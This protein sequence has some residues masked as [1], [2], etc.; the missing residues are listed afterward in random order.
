MSEWTPPPGH[1]VD[2]RAEREAIEAVLER[3]DHLDE[4]ALDELPFGLIQLDET[5]RILSFNRTEAELAQINR[6]RQIGRNFFDE[7]A[8]C[9]RVKAFHGRFLSGVARKELNESFGFLFQ[10]PHGARYVAIT[11]YYSQRKAS[12]WV[13]VSKA[14]P[15]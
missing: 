1:P 7:V 14:S 9:T 8:P 12:V 15:T 3:L 13:I 11:L 4:A 2:V 5:G 6:R 10:F